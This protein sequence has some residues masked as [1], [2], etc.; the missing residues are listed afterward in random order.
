MKGHIHGY[1]DSIRINRINRFLCHV[2]RSLKFI[3]YQAGASD[4]RYILHSGF[5]F[6]LIYC[7]W[8]WLQCTSSE[9]RHFTKHVLEKVKYRNFCLKL[10]FFWQF[11]FCLF[12]YHFSVYYIDSSLSTDGRTDRQFMSQKEREREI[13][14]FRKPEYSNLGRSDCFYSC[15]Q[16]CPVEFQLL[17]LPFCGVWTNRY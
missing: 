3:F 4:T 7:Y 1:V 5:L 14:T 8:M 10:Y 16:V 2:E 15:L 6:I 12:S 13:C 11:M 9:L 17:F